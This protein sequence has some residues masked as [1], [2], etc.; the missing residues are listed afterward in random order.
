MSYGARPGPKIISCARA[1]CP[2]RPTWLRLLVF[3]AILWQASHGVIA[4]TDGEALFEADVIDTNTNEALRNFQVLAGV[5][6]NGVHED[7]IAVWQP[8]TIREG[9]DGKFQWPR[10][11]AYRKFRLRF[12]ADGYKPHLTQWLERNQATVSETIRLERDPGVR[13]RVLQPDGQ[14]ARGAMLGIA[15]AN[16]E[17]R[18]ENGQ[19]KH[20]DDPLPKKTISALATSTN[21]HNRRTGTLQTDR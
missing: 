19:F 12:E 7:A 21:L 8:H 11:R 17:V 15:M 14:P 4:Q 1:Y 16:R 13:G 9:V 6:F 20:V 10:R 3:A 2:S 18:L 5:P